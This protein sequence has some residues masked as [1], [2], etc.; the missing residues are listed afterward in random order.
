MLNKGRYV[1]PMSMDLTKVFDTVHHYL[2]IVRLGVLFFHR[3]V[4]ST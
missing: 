1:C 3:M 4:F 2:K